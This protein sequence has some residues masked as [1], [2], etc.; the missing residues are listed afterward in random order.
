[1]PNK[2]SGNSISQRTAQRHKNDKLLENAPLLYCTCGDS[3]CDPT[4]LQ[5]QLTIQRH[6]RNAKDRKK[7]KIK[8]LCPCK[9]FFCNPNKLYGPSSI[10]KH[11]KKKRQ[12]QDIPPL[13]EHKGSLSEPDDT[14]NDS[15]GQ[16]NDNTDDEPPNPTEANT[17]SQHSS[18][19]SSNQTAIP[20]N[21][22][23]TSIIQPSTCENTWNNPQQIPLNT[24]STFNIRANVL[25]KDRPPDPLK[26]RVP[27]NHVIH[28]AVE[29][30]SDDSTEDERPLNQESMDQHSAYAQQDPDVLPEASEDVELEVNEEEDISHLD[31]LP[32]SADFLD[33]AAEMDL[34][35]DKETEWEE[36]LGS[37][38]SVIML[39]TLLFLW[40]KKYNINNTA[41]RGLFRIIK[42]V[43]NKV[44]G[45]DKTK[46]NIPSFDKSRKRFRPDGGCKAERKDVC[47]KCEWLYLNNEDQNCPIE[48]CK[49][50][51]YKTVGA[52]TVPRKS[53]FKWD[54]LSQLK[55]RMNWK[56]FRSKLQSIPGVATCN[57]EDIISSKAITDKVRQNINVA[58]QLGKFVFILALA[59][60]GFNPWRGVQYTMWFL[61][62][63]IMNMNVKFTAKTE[64]L[65]TIGIISGP[66]EPKT[67]QHYMTDIVVQ[68]LYIQANDVTIPYTLD[69]GTTVLKG[70]A[71]FLTNL[72]GDYPALCKLLHIQGVGKLTPHTYFFYASDYN[73][74]IPSYY[75]L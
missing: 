31:G 6:L 21:V 43:I 13:N 17:Q 73:Y 9:Q 39:I 64:E 30:V 49:E 69:D 22:V 51:R 71:V 14:D 2:R 62:L 57:G 3:K 68:L 35:D 4:Q 52:K 32:E 61:A 33:G 23:V 47:D 10:S 63:R 7:N 58:T 24:V 25:K 26:H 36:L 74:L 44:G 8:K 15:Y 37:S 12:Q 18:I 59:C 5:N 16:I 11:M 70:I 60:D 29:P 67:L 55:M 75:L 41:M 40:Q 27:L 42:I 66:R 46:P 38:M 45:D 56:D 65:I 19:I 72:I 53:Y 1:M 54:I 20:S 34:D 50:Y 28:S 48:W